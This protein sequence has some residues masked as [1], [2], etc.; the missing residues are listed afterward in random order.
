MI[1]GSHFPESQIAFL[2]TS[3][4]EVGKRFAFSGLLAERVTMN[5]AQPPDNVTRVGKSKQPDFD[6]EFLYII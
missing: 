5:I 4:Y 1:C 2:T 6:S 3:T